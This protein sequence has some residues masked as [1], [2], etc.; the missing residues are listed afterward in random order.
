MPLND[1]FR[2]RSRHGRPRESGRL[3]VLVAL[4]LLALGACGGGGGGGSGSGN[5]APAVPTV[6]IGAA[7]ADESADPTDLVFPVTLSA[8]AGSAV[9]VDYR[10]EG[11]T[12]EPGSDFVSANGTLTVPPGTTAASIRVG[13]LDD[14]D[15]EPD[16]TLVLRLS[17]PVNARLGT[18][19]AA[20]LIRDNDVA[21]PAPVVGLDER[22]SN[23]TCVAP[24]RGTGDAEV[25]LEPAF[26]G[27]PDFAQPTGLVQAP[28]ADG[29]WFVLEKSGRV[30]V[31]ADDPAASAAPVWLDIAGQ[32]N[33][34]SEGGLLGLAFDPDWPA[35]SEVYV[36][37]TDGGGGG[38]RSVVSR[39]VPDN[40]T[41][42]ANWTEEVV[43]TVSQDFDNH[44]GGHI[45]F[46]PDRLLYLGL[47]DGG[48]GGDP[49][50]RA[51][52]TTRLLGSFLRL[53][54]R[55][56]PWPTPAY[57]IP[58]GNPFAANAVCGPGA[59]TAACP[60][61]FAWGFRNPWRWSF[62]TASG[63]LWAGDVGQGAWE[64][65][66]QVEAGGNYGWDCREGAHDFQPAN[67]SG[68][69]LV[70]PVA[71]YSHSLG[72]SITGGYVYRGSAIPALAG[73]YVFGDFG[74][75]RIWALAEDGGGY[76]LEE[77]VDSSLNISSFGQG[78]DGEIYVVNLGGDFRKL[79]AAGGGGVDPV[80]DL[81]SETGC[82]AAGDATQPA[83]G[84]V[85]YTL[86]APF[87]SDGADK[88]RWIGLPDDAV[89]EIDGDG[90]WQFPAGTILVKQFELTGRLV[91]TRLLMR[92]PDG[93]WAGYTYAW[94]EAGTD[95]DRVR[96]GLVRTI[97]GQDWIY[98]GESQ[99]LECHTQAAGVSLGLE[100]AQ[101]NG[102]LTYS[103]TG[104]T[105][106]QLTTLEHIGFF[107]DPLPGG[108]EDLPMLTD[109]ADAAADPGL[110]ARAYLHTN[111][112]QC[113]RPGG[114]TPVDM[115]FRWTVA[116]QDTNTCGVRATGGGIGM[117]GGV[118]I[119]PGA[120]N[121]S[122]AVQRMG[123][124]DAGG[125]PPIGSTVVDA[126]GLGQVSEWIDSLTGCN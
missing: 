62:D 93:E 16:E 71:E 119:A 56:V 72:N 112:S 41:S 44:N 18:A 86:N 61:I 20:G 83:S 30:R 107:A 35:T 19:E 7:S 48:S 52:D 25:I 37:Y 114:P 117:M 111:C 123:R 115:D 79:T 12:A 103:S 92:H 28:P 74:S 60:E 29:R 82:T 84:L 109:P 89:I 110:R 26:G 116:L 33:D 38:M 104:R 1:I 40:P 105:A 78:A 31:F 22:P 125:M 14:T 10:S 85:P 96:G 80:A 5:P 121:R 126:D 88:S 46:G 49:N 63:V 81:L 124:R 24:P 120:A 98:P 99:C 59:N 95:A 106:N 54:V 17:N 27:L 36:S 2:Y 66:D 57:R 6:S 77:L 53:D 91:E 8:P 4:P 97:D 108:P 34:R 94:N 68:G 58:P 122:V 50:N 9:T 69:G 87:W 21:Q 113:H 70:E 64:E 90:D 32:V 101:Q 13:V 76:A 43:L 73:R 118:R 55:G 65:V 23:T 11:G 51:Q 45:A 47:G 39:F 100:T 3:G 42:P 102:D 67:C 75:G 15:V